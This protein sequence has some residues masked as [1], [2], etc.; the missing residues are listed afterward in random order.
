MAVAVAIGEEEE[1]GIKRRR[2]VRP[3]DSSV[4]ARGGVEMHCACSVRGGCFVWFCGVPLM[5]PGPRAESTEHEFWKMAIL[6]SSFF[7]HFL[8]A[9]YWFV[10]LFVRIFKQVV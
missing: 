7:R 9:E 4:G 5:P 10:R 2:G 3:L 8:T 6:N 1:E